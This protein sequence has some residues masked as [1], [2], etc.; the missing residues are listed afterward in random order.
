MESHSS[1]NNNNTSNNYSTPSS[2]LPPLP[3]SSPRP[4]PLP[5]PARPA[6]E[7][8]S[9]KSRKHAVGEGVGSAAL[10]ET[11]NR[12]ETTTTGGYERD[13]ATGDSFSSASFSPLIPPRSL[14]QN[15]NNNL[16]LSTEASGLEQ[17]PS[18]QTYMSTPTSTTGP[19]SSKRMKKKKMS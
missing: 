19:P 8:K 9:K 4:P 17:S 1:S 18:G 15:N 11:F 16:Q 14:I 12:D 10:R 7:R 3:M 5:A 6:G 13:E 2:P